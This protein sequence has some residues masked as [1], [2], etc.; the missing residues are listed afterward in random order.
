MSD[1][2]PP[3]P[4]DEHATALLDAGV[5][6]PA[7]DRALAERLAQLRA[8][9]DAVADVP[10]PDA[11]RREQA[12]IAALAAFD[13]GHGS[14]GTVVPLA[15]RANRRRGRWATGIGG[16]LAVAAALVGVGILAARG[17]GGSGSS[18]ALGRAGTATSGGAAAAEAAGSA[19][20]GAQDAPKAAVATTAASATFSAASATTAAGAATTTKSAAGAS[21]STTAAATATAAATTVAAPT[22]T[23]SIGAALPY[24]G[25]VGSTVDLDRVVRRILDTSPTPTTTDTA[26]PGESGSDVRQAF[27]AAR[28][29]VGDQGAPIALARYQGRAAV[30]TLAGD[31]VR[32]VG[33]DDCAVI[34]S[35]PRTG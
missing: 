20:A 12:I 5:D 9:R 1:L 7:G 8:V 15:P 4:L 23:A 21:A 26:T 28:C 35:R 22:T 29:N 27:A 2:P 10:A 13:A 14:P 3:L 32:V 6:A 25:D 11:A 17:S 33:I 31:E 24:V 34:V 19:T 16:G 30:L 18:T